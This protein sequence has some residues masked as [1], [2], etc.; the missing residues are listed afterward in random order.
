MH[1][2]LSVPALYNDGIEDIYR[3]I[4]AFLHEQLAARATPGTTAG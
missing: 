4:V 3:Q 1:A 2:S